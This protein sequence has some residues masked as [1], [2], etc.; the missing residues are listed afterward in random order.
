MRGKG[1]RERQTG[2]GKKVQKAGESRVMPLSRQ[3]ASLM[4]RKQFI[5]AEKRSRENV[6]TGPCCGARR[7]SAHT[8]KEEERSTANV[9]HNAHYNDTDQKAHWCVSLTHKLTL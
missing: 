7:C 1:R 3:E 9:T 8:G 4:G 2:E 6:M 5:C